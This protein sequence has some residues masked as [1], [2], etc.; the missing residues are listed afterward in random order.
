[1]TLHLPGQVFL[2]SRDGIKKWLHRNK[3]KSSSV[4][5]AVDLG[6]KRSLFYPKLE[7]RTRFSWQSGCFCFGLVVCFQGVL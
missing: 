5:T 4:S 1:M 6:L 2:A 3:H 7:F